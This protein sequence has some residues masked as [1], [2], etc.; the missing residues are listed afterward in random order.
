MVSK[1][2][3]FEALFKL[4]FSMPTLIATDFFEI[5]NIFI[6]SNCSMSFYLVLLKQILFLANLNISVEL[7]FALEVLNQHCEE[8]HG[9]LSGL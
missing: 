6:L 8:M 5:Q 9:V 1:A 7:F 2:N 3:K 4:S